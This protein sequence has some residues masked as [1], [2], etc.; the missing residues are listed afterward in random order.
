[1]VSPL[2]SLFFAVMI[3]SY[4]ILSDVWE[5]LHMHHAPP[6]LGVLYGLVV[7]IICVVALSGC[8]GLPTFY[9]PGQQPSY[10]SSLST[11][12]GAMTR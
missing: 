8:A 1:M 9:P 10:W 5:D 12:V 4:P 3:K 2:A 6:I 7:L 11:A